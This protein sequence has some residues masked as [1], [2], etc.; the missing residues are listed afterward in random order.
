VYHSSS[1]QAQWNPETLALQQFEIPDEC[2]S[3]LTADSTAGK[4]S[5]GR[6]ARR[7]GTM[8]VMDLEP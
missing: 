6:W 8:V 5:S 2:G 3:S 4:P 7:G 1:L